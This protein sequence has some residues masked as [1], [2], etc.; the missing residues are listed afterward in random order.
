MAAEGVKSLILLGET[1]SLIE[2]LAREEGFTD[3]SI[4]PD[5]HAAVQKAFRSAT[6]GDTVLLSPAC[7]SWDM[8]KNFEE[9]GEVFK[10]AVI[11]LKEALESE[12]CPYRA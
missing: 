9:R 2:L 7:A 11:S 5:L 4:V 10:S 12:K 6:S 3:V 8:F 1:A